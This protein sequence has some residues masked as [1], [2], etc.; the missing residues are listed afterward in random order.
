MRWTRSCGIREWR[1]Q[2]ARVLSSFIP[3]LF[4]SPPRT[5]SC[6]GVDEGFGKQQLHLLHDGLG[7]V[8]RTILAKKPVWH[9]PPTLLV[10]DRRRSDTGCRRAGPQ[11]VLTVCATYKTTPLSC[12][13]LRLS[14]LAS[15]SEERY[16]GS[17]GMWTLLRRIALTCSTE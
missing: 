2:F 12:F 6:H 3:A 5:S 11:N 7:A 15:S 1:F 16:R 13:E 8:L 9:P 14:P 4:R 17:L 10:I